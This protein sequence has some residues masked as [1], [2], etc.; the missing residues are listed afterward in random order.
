MQIIETHIRNKN[1]YS[2][3]DT[4]GNPRVKPITI[5][6]NNTQ[7][8]ARKNAEE[9]KIALAEFFKKSIEYREWDRSK[10]E[11][12]AHSKIILVTTDTNKSEYQKQLEIRLASKGNSLQK[13]SWHKE[14]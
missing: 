1:L 8:S 12:L 5:F 10:L 6:I 7:A 13:Q 4:L 14:L 11:A 3:K 9:F 2:Y